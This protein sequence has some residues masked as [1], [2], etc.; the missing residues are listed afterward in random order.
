M[1]SPASIDWI[2]AADNYV[3]LHCGSATHVLRET[4]SGLESQ[5]DPAAFVRIHRSAIVNLHRVREIQPWFRGD[6]RLVLD[7]GTVLTLSR[8]YR[9][10]VQTALFGLAGSMAR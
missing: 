1:L 10:R 3:C 7:N 4:M 6:S 8:T 5:L 9:G 2:E